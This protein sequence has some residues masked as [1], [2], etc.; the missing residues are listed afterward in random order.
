M[1]WSRSGEIRSLGTLPG[2]DYS[3]AFAINQA[4]EVVGASTSASGKRAF[5]WTLQ[6]GMVD[7]GVLAV[8]TS[9]KALRITDSGLVVGASTSPVSSHAILWSRQ[10]RMQDIGSVAGGTYAEALGANNA[11]VV[12]GASQ[13]P[14]GGRAF[15]WKNNSGVQDLNVLIPSRRDVVLAAALH[16]NERGQIVAIGSS[17]HDSTRERFTHPDDHLHAGPIHVFLLTPTAQHQV[18]WPARSGKQ[19]RIQTLKEFRSKRGG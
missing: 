8:D 7:L 16:I 5:L 18:V 2:G 4:G 3:E 15:I 14:L 1:L 9:S 11:G 12:V 13:T 19:H 10:N 17:H 6:D